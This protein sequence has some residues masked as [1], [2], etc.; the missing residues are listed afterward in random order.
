MATFSFLAHGKKIQ[1]TELFHRVIR[2]TAYKHFGDATS[3]GI[4]LGGMPKEFQLELRHY[5]SNNLI[6]ALNL[7]RGSSWNRVQVRSTGSGATT[8]PA[9]IAEYGAYQDYIGLMST[10][11]SGTAISVYTQ[12]M[13]GSNSLGYVKTTTGP[14][15]NVN[16]LLL[17]TGDPGID[18]C[19]FS[20]NPINFSFD[21][22]RILTY[23]STADSGTL[24]YI[25]DDE[26]FIPLTGGA[27]TTNHSTSAGGSTLYFTRFHTRVFSR[28]ENGNLKFSTNMRGS[29]QSTSPHSRPA[30]GVMPVSVMVIKDTPSA[31]YISPDFSW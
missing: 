2:C 25:A 22:K 18:L 7:P 16:K 19:S 28:D 26:A 1:H 29:G 5:S 23:S 9:I 30:S 15:L 27:Y 11:Q 13:A 3:N 31:N 6:V 14:R 17:Y 24:G 20:S 21:V 4:R 8:D 12:T 10:H